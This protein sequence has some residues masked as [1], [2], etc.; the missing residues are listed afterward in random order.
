MKLSVIMLAVAVAI[1]FLSSSAALCY[2]YDSMPATIEYTARRNLS[3][4]LAFI[5]VPFGI[6]VP[7]LIVINHEVNK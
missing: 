3:G 4:F 7:I 1:V 6:G 2:I 5:S